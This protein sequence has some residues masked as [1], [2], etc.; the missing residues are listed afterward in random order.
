MTYIPRNPPAEPAQLQSFLMFEL[1]K[2]AQEWQAW[3]PFLALDTLYAEPRKPRTGMIVKADGTTWNPGAGAGLYW[4]DGTYWRPF[5][6]SHPV[7][8]YVGGAP[9]TSEVVMR[10]VATDRFLLPASLTGSKGDAA[11]AATA[12]TDFTVKKGAT[13]IGT[14]RFAASATTATFIAASETQFTAGDVL[15]IVAPGTPDATLAGISITL[16]GWRN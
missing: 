15:S 4:Y 1:Q 10:F 11:T 8:C 16:Q 9:T 14:V 5:G 2:I 6:G 12:Q 3:Q 7:G 13:S